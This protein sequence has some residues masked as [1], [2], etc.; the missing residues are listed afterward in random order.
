MAALEEPE[1]IGVGRTEPIET[2]VYRGGASGGKAFLVLLVVGL[3]ALGFLKSG[4]EESESSVENQEVVGEDPDSTVATTT[5]RR[6]LTTSRPTTTSRVLVDELG[7]V[8]GFDTG[9]N[10]YVGGDGSLVRLGLDDGVTEDLGS[11][12][13][14][15]AVVGDYL[16]YSSPRTDSVSYV[17]LGSKDEDPIRIPGV[18]PIFGP[19]QPVV[20]GETEGRIW[21]LGGPWESQTW[22][23]WELGAEPVL[24]SERQAP[25]TGFGPA[26]AHPVVIGASSGGV[27][28]RDGDQITKVADGRLISVIQTHAVIEQCESPF[29][30][31]VLWFKLDSWEADT[32]IRTPQI[33]NP[34]FLFLMVASPNAKYAFVYDYSDASTS[35]ALWNLETG[36]AEFH[37]FTEEG[38]GFSADGRFAAGFFRSGNVA[39]IDTDTGELV[40]VDLPGVS[41]YGRIVFGPAT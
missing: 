28:V 14:P 7:P 6:S 5:P 13:T 30:C 10:M 37:G 15:M 33:E 21:L 24:L 19:Q 41:G 9:W 31:E 34:Y 1:L 8:F 29:D 23:L 17:P 35:G 26:P 20:A 3:I 25:P 36:E 11:G 12:R 40:E 32:S 39:I 16:V 2:E 27:F 4:T 22:Q 18:R 38:A